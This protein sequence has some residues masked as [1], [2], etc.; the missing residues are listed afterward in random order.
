MAHYTIEDIEILRQKSGLSYEEAVNLLEYHNG[1]LAR[2]L[3]D[4]ERNGRLRDEQPRPYGHARKYHRRGLF[5]TLFRLRVKINK[6]NAPVINLSVLFM[7]FALLVAPWLVVI[8]LVAALV[9]GYRINIERDSAEFGNESLDDIVKNAGSNM[10]NAARTIARDLGV[11]TESQAQ[12]GQPE[13][14]P[15]AESRAEPPKSNTTPVN[16]QFSE[17]GN[18]RVTEDEDGY[19]EADVQ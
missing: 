9:M 12:A 5:I 18:V 10:R 17:D 15:E 7:I 14:A 2:S 13:T 11:K 19:H 3:V 16:V 8:S 1:S 4:L 6:D